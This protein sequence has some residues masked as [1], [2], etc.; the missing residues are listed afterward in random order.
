MKLLPII[1]FFA[2]LIIS[3]LVLG[4]LYLLFILST[5][6]LAGG[7][8][9]EQIEGHR[10]ALLIGAIILAIIAGMTARFFF[11]SGRKLAAYGISVLPL[12]A[13][14]AVA[15]FYFAS[16]YSPSQFDKAVWE[17]EQWK[18]LD[19]ATTLV[20]EKK[21]IGMARREVKEMLGPGFQEHGD[22][23]SDR[24]VILYLVKEDWTLTVLFQNDKVVSA[25]LRL[26]ILGV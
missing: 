18:P 5:F 25:D 22:A 14:L 19:M 26:P 13:L 6:N 12:I 4:A 24:G 15:V 1:S 2:G 7:E 10:T 17:Q 21:L 3:G 11:K 9:L 8:T 23:N 16:L 20:K